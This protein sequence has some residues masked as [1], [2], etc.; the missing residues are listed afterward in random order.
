ML[1]S[2]KKFNQVNNLFNLIDNNDVLAIHDILKK[3][4]SLINSCENELTPLLYI[5][6][7]KRFHLFDVLANYNPSFEKTTPDRENALHLVVK[8]NHV[9]LTK[10]LLKLNKLDPNSKNKNGYTPLF[11]AIMNNNEK[12]ALLL[13]DNGASL[14]LINWFDY[15]CDYEPIKIKIIEHQKRQYKE[16]FEQEK[17]HSKNKRVKF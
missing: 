13:L 6:E 9:I 17:I 15:L 1:N 12:I 7:K 16:D 8:E 10:K 3:D 11:Y 5:L 4:S 2:N 14:D